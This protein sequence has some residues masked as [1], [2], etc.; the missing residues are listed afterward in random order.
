MEREAVQPVDL[1]ASEI[2][3]R[4]GSSWIPPEIYQQFMYDL[5]DTPYYCR[6]NIKVHFSQ[7]TGEWN[8]EGK[9]YD[10]GNI[11]AYSAYGTERINGYKILEQSLATCTRAYAQ[12]YNVRRSVIASSKENFHDLI[13]CSLERHEV[14]TAYEYLKKDILFME[15]ELLNTSILQLDNS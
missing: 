1:D 11:K 12:L 15:Q 5:F 4:L 13:V 6:Y 14:Y 10:R 2:S 7:Y 8:I 9:S 3:V